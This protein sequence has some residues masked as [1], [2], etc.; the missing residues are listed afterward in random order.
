MIVD[1]VGCG[2]AINPELAFALER[3][4]KGFKCGAVIQVIV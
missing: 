2:R 3:G 1:D 4:M